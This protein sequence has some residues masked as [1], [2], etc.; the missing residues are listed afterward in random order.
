MMRTTHFRKIFKW[1]CPFKENDLQSIFKANLAYTVSA[2]QELTIIPQNLRCNG[3]EAFVNIYSCN[4]TVTELTMTGDLFT[5]RNVFDKMTQRDTVSWNCM[6]SGY[7]RNGH[8]EEA[9]RLLSRFLSENLRPNERTFSIALSSCAET[10]ALI[11]GKQIHGLLIKTGFCGYVYVGTSLIT[12]YSKCRDPG[13]L[14]EIFNGITQCN[15]AS[16]NALL[17][18]FA[19]NFWISEARWVFDHMPLKNVV[20]WT[21]MIN[22]Y[23]EM[24]K[25]NEAYRLFR[26]MAERNSVTWAVMISGFVNDGQYERGLTLFVDMM[27]CIKDFRA[28]KRMVISAFNACAGIKFVNLGMAIHGFILKIGLDFDEILQ[29]SIITFYAKCMPIEEA[30]VEFEKMQVQSI[31]SWNAI[32]SGYVNNNR[33]EEAWELFNDM[34]E[35]DSISWDILIN[36]YAKKG[37]ME[38]A[39]F[40]FER[41]PE[42]TV[43]TW[44]S[45][46][47][48]MI[49]N[50]C[51]DDAKRFFERM[52]ERD[53]VSFTVMIN[54][55][56]REGKIE[57]AEDFFKRMPEKNA[58]AYNVMIDGFAR[59]G[60]LV[61]ARKLFEEVK[62]PD[63]LSW[64]SMIGGYMNLGHY[65]CALELYNRMIFTGLC[66]NESILTS[67]LTACASLALLKFGHEVHVLSIKIG[68]QSYS[69]VANSL[70]NMYSKCGDIV[71]AESIF[72]KMENRDLVTWNALISGYSVNGN[73]PKAIVAFEKLVSM[74]IKPDS[75][76]FLSLLLACS[77]AGLAKQSWNYFSIMSS[78]YGIKPEKSH[79]GCMVDLL[80]RLGLVVEAEKLVSSMPFEP[81]SVIWTSLLNGCKAKPNF[82]IA[83]RAANKLIKA[84]SRD[85]SPYLQLISIHGSERRWVHAENVSD[86]MEKKKVRKRP[87]CSWIEIN[88]EMH[89]FYA[90]DQ[91]HPLNQELQTHLR[92]LISDIKKL[93]YVPNCSL[94][95][96]D[97]EDQ[98]KEEVL[99][100]HSEKL[101]IALGLLKQANSKPIR[102]IKNLR[103]CVDCHTAIKL[104][105]LS[106]GRE[107]IMR[108]GLRFHHFKDGSCS[109][110]DYW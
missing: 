88:G 48:G 14:M 26:S 8:Y 28:I 59:H 91:S 16:W 40:L 79:Y 25:I 45:L 31:G 54:G 74:E 90:S 72:N 21:S 18:G 27:A 83:Q 47:S 51:I 46:I 63:I 100:Q 78:I 110:S 43:I 32:I 69:I 52:P 50:K 2:T 44:T 109:C 82:D 67:I 71:T 62:E 55:L 94:V 11:Q 103:V 53:T 86:N 39:I 97:L 33:I 92:T 49:E 6:M 87:G 22:G 81:D 20:S 9:L 105:S 29:S 38:K 99:I 3:D 64:A 15:L 19:S 66:P 57:E 98:E 35:P 68:L 56:V 76:T 75:V 23:V 13:S 61:E 60:R 65:E 107:I 1:F 95:M 85:P 42:P 37:L 24:K 41:M 12:F 106:S 7:S 5:A 102:V 84:N 93:G 36:G 89:H 96:Q 80:S 17:S 58:I 77:H 70:I 73:A 108:D 104:I 101:A 10:R 4:S 34:P 30:R